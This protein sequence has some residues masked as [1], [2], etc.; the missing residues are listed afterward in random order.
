MYRFEEVIVVLEQKNQYCE[1]KKKKT[2]YK[3]NNTLNKDD[4]I[5]GSQISV[6]WQCN[7]ITIPHA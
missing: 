4:D 1:K 5:G 6:M 7:F 2:P 3:I